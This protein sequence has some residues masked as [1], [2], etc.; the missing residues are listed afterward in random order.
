MM[1]GQN[2]VKVWDPLVR[3]VHWGLVVTFFT[4]YAIEEPEA[5]HVWVGYAVLVLALVRVVWGFVG[6]PHARFPDFVYGPGTVLGNLKDIVLMHPKRYLG[7]SPAGGAMVVLL[8]LGLLGTTV[9]GVMLY[10]ADEHAGPLA[11]WMAGVSEHALEEPHEVLANVTLALVIVHIAGVIVAS[12][13][14]K[15]NLARAMIT[16]RKRSQ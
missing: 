11:G 10:G 12:L 9:T 7:H 2:E 15:E 13:T 4:A 16:G 1:Q 5:I 14:H 6:T 3:I 8:L